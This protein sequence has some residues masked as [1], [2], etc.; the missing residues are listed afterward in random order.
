MEFH[1]AIFSDS[2][3]LIQKVYDIKDMIQLSVISNFQ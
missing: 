3:I 1:P 2:E